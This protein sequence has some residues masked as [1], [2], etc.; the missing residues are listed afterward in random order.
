MG[1][2]AAHVGA[3]LG[4]DRLGR[5]L[6]DAGDRVQLFQ[7]TCERAGPPIDLLAKRLDDLVEVVEVGEDVRAEQRVVG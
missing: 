2:E 3:E 5:A 7:L 1:G 6:A 4:Q